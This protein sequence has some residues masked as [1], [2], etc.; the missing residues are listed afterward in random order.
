MAR[1]SSSAVQPVLTDLAEIVHVT[2]LD[3]PPW[4]VS[5]QFRF[6][7]G[8]LQVEVDPDDDT[9]EVPFDPRHRPPL[10]HWASRSVPRQMNQRYADLLGRTSAWRWLLRNQQQYEDGFQIELST[11]SSTT[12]LQYLA[13]ASRLDLRHVNHAPMP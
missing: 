12:A 3:D 9:V 5:V 8:Y 4:L 13:M 7:E 1:D 10:H 6:D 11:P 2:Y